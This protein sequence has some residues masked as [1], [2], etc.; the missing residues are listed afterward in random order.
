MNY[1]YPSQEVDNTM[2]LQSWDVLSLSIGYMVKR[3]MQ[4]S[5]YLINLGN[6]QGWDFSSDL[7]DEIKHNTH[8]AIVLTDTEQTIVWVNNNFINLT[9]YPSSE[10]LGRNPKFLQGKK[11]NQPAANKIR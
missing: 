8:K 2:P 1:P 9:G 3:H 6:E 10:L 4:E 11:Q 7:L 5:T